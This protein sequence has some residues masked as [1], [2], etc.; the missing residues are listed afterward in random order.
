MSLRFPI[1]LVLSFLC[2][3]TAAWAGFET[4]MGGYQRG[5]Y[6]IAVSEWRP[7]AEQGDPG[8]QFYLGLLYE[9]GAGLPQDYTTARKWYEKAA[10]QGYAMAQTSLG[11][12]YEKGA[13]LPQDYTTA[14]K[15]YEKAAFRGYPM[16]QTNLGL[17]YRSGHG[18]PQDDMRAYM[19]FSLAAAHLT[20][21]LQKPGADSRDKTASLL[22]PA[23][24]AEAQ[25]LA[26]R[27]QAQQF[28]GC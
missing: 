14:R 4:G 21:N 11:V 8:A 17:L 22:T 10:T 24:I 25:R 26:R 7:L 3:P 5:D 1:V 13:G 19:W 18:V 6:A 12:L 20:G 27:C 15:W 9:K 2:L 28:K 16:A 23:Q